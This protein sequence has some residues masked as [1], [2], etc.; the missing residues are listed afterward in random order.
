MVNNAALNWWLKY[1]GVLR[2]LRHAPSHILY[3]I[4]THCGMRR[5]VA[6]TLWI[7]HYISSSKWTVNSYWHWYYECLQVA[8]TLYLV[9]GC[10]PPTVREPRDDPSGILTW[11]RA[12]GSRRWDIDFIAASYTSIDYTDT[13][14]LLS[15]T[16]SNRLW[17]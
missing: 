1:L 6:T 2:A 3:I 7:S 4:C 9:N 16:S 10:T 15:V 13:S 8:I 12:C 11:Y 17:L 5:N 14:N